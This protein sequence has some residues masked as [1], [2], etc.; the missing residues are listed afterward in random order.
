MITKP[1]KN[2]L[3]QSIRTNGKLIL[4][5][6]FI[7]L[8]AGVLLSIGRGIPAFASMFSD[9]LLT[10][11]VID[12]PVKIAGGATTIILLLKSKSYSDWQET[13]PNNPITKKE[14]AAATYLEMFIS[15]F[16]GIPTLIIIWIVAAVVDPSVVD[17]MFTYGVF[18]VGGMIF[19]V[20]MMIS[21]VYILQFTKLV[22]ISQGSMVLIVGLFSSLW[23][24]MGVQNILISMNL[25]RIIAAFIC[26]ILG[27]IILA[28]SWKVTTILYE[29]KE[30][31]NG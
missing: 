23:T 5:V 20:W 27:L 9:H 3:T 18:N 10:E 28:I 19:L 14:F 6:H 24:T 1:V 4:I 11:F 13:F 22:K 7:I 30:M 15:A 26:V 16:L 21:V 8:F 17:A 25:N 31:Q 29:K 2:Y 12:L